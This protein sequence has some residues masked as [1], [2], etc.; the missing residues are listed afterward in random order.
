[1]QKRELATLNDI[2]LIVIPDLVSRKSYVIKVF[3]KVKAIVNEL[4]IGSP[5]F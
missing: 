2:N 4:L 5:T 3:E 1:M